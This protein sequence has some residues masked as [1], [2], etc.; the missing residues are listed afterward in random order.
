MADSFSDTESI[1]SV[2]IEPS[3][4]DMPPSGIESTDSAA[5]V[6]EPELSSDSRPLVSLLDV[7]KAPTPSILARKRKILQTR[8]RE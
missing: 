1:E 7:L 3:D 6:T 2:I 5:A 4:S 8:R